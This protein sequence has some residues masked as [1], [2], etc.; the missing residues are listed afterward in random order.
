M[1]GTGVD[2][3]RYRYAFCTL[4]AFRKLGLHNDVMAHVMYEYFRK[5]FSTSTRLYRHA[6]MDISDSTTVAR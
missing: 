5:L 2:V 4:H 1:V 6:G 3:R